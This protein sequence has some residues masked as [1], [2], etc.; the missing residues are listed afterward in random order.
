MFRRAYRG[1]QLQATHE[2][3]SEPIELLASILSL[4]GLFII[5]TS[6]KLK[7]QFSLQIFIKL[8]IKSK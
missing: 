6:P 5:F 4:Q 3:S 7:W 1:S 8:C 2:N